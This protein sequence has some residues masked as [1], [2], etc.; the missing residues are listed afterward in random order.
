[1]LSSQKIIAGSRERSSRIVRMSDSPLRRNS[2]IWV[3]E[4]SACS[5]LVR[6][7]AK[8]WCQNSASFS[9]SWFSE[10]IIRNNHV[11]R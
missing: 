7:V 10:L 6:P 11:A 8:T 4:A 3:D 1:M 2:S 5:F 9:C